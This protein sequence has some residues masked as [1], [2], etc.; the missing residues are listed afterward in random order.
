MIIKGPVQLELLR[1]AIGLASYKQTNKTA[2]TFLKL[3][4]LINNNT[5]QTVKDHNLWLFWD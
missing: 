3:N 2:K 5:L 1:G 4:V